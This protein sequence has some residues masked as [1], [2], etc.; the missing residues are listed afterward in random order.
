VL[1]VPTVIHNGAIFAPVRVGELLRTNGGYEGQPIT[2]LAMQLAPH[3]FVRLGELRH[4]ACQEFDLERALWTIP[5]GTTKMC[6]DHL[7]PLSHQTI[8]ILEDLSTLTGPD[9]YVFASIRSRKRPMSDNTINAGP[10]RLGDSTDEMTAHRFRAS[11]ST[12]LNESRKWH[13][14]AIDRPPRA[15][16]AAAIMGRPI[17]S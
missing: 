4:A 17:A 7:V 6:K 15:R 8:A 16:M 12:L 3:V 1:T 14:D 13:P 10:R 9:G 5:A 2:N 11:A